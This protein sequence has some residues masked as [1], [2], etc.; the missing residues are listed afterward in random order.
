MHASVCVCV[1]VH[2]S[3]TISKK[4]KYL[5]FCLSFFLDISSRIVPIKN[6][7]I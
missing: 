3:K 7:N 1:C 4:S 2:V 5:V 6:N